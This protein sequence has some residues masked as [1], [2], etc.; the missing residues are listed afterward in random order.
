V[1]RVQEKGAADQIDGNGGCAAD[2]ANQ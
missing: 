1:V 2:A